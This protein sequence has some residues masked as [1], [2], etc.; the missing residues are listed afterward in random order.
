MRT[1]I[2]PNIIVLLIFS[3]SGF[4]NATAQQKSDYEI[5]LE[6][7]NELKSLKDA[8]RTSYIPQRTNDQKLVK[9]ELDNYITKIYA[10]Y[11]NK[12]P[13]GLKEL[14]PVVTERFKS[15][16]DKREEA[17]KQ[18]LTKVSEFLDKWKAPEKKNIVEKVGK[19]YDLNFDE[20]ISLIDDIKTDLELE[21]NEN[22]DRLKDF[23]VVIIED[24]GQLIVLK[25][26]LD[27]ISLRVKKMLT[28]ST[29]DKK[30]ISDLIAENN[31][32][33]E[34]ILKLVNTIIAEHKLLPS[35]DI[36]EIRP[37]PF[38]SEMFNT[39]N[40]FMDDYINLTSTL[41]GDPDPAN[42][43]NAISAQKD[44]SKKFDSLYESCEKAKML[45]K[46]EKDQLTVKSQQWKNDL[47]NTLD[48][49]IIKEFSDNGVPIIFHKDNSLTWFAK[50]I[51]EFITP[52]TNPGDEVNKDLSKSSKIQ[53]SFTTAWN[54]IKT[55][56]GAALSE[57]EYLNEKSQ[58]DID[59]KLNSWKDVAGGGILS[60]PWI[61]IGLVAAIAIIIGLIAVLLRKKK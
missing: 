37:S 6:F 3:F 60:K 54:D 14:I 40:G 31:R 26:S 58:S 23:L 2:F 33:K 41:K 28:E 24:K 10:D 30:M 43:K 52:Y 15:F 19:D 5:F 27:N 53:N 16:K 59:T 42:M 4:I 36:S 57:A 34:L 61:I 25:D 1:K 22:Y 47:Y 56:W 44:F 29:R 48:N 55:K 45:N 49:A 9:D 32:R 13:E 20:Q 46:G 17:K 8:F 38:A 39:L 50:S 21:N 12:N 11:S 18:K 51:S 7:K 35:K